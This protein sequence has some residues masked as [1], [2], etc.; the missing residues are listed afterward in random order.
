MPKAGRV[1]IVALALSVPQPRASAQGVANEYRI[2]AA[3]VYQFPQFVEW[4]AA[5]WQDARTLQL[6]IVE[7]NPFGAELEQL[8]RGEVLN[9]RPLAVRYIAGA[10]ALP[11]CHLLFIGSHA[12]AT[13]A[14]L[15]A[16]AARPI[17]TVG[18][19][20][21][22]LEHGGAIVLKVVDRR[23]RFEVSRTNA[24]RAGLRISSQLLSLALAVRGGPS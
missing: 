1:L 18:E 14:L 17:L 24:E 10:E 2:K 7:P 8:V 23:V 22:F 20:D 6:C 3:F 16:A 12:D 13:P 19:W 15:K 4:P 9:G 5:A 21:D 11:G